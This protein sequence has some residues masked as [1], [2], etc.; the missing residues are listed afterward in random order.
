[1]SL[2][3]LN[4]TS[5]CK[6]FILKLHTLGVALELASYSH[7]RFPLAKICSCQGCEEPCRVQEDDLCTLRYTDTSEGWGVHVTTSKQVIHHVG[8]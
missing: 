4:L 3:V 1:M 6:L 5:F 7:V 8:L 2:F